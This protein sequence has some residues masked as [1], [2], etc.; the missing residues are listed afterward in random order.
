MFLVKSLLF[1]L[2]YIALN[3]MFKIDSFGYLMSEFGPMFEKMRK[4]S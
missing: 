2:L 4:Q 3:Y 1:S